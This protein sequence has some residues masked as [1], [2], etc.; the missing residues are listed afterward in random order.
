MAVPSQTTIYLQSVS[1]LITTIPF[2]KVYQIE[3][4][5]QVWI[6]NTLID[7]SL[8]TWDG[9]NV[10]FTPPKTLNGILYVYLIVPMNRINNFNTG[11]ALRLDDI[12]NQFDKIIL[13]LQSINSI[14][15][16]SPRYN[17]ALTPS[18]NDTDLT[19]LVNSSYWQKS[20]GFIITKKLLDYVLT[21]PFV[22]I[23][24]VPLLTNQNSITT[25]DI[26]GT[27]LNYT[28]YSTVVTIATPIDGLIHFY[29]INNKNQFGKTE[30]IGYIYY[31]N[32]IWNNTTKDNGIVNFNIVNNVAISLNP[33]DYIKFSANLV[34][35]F[36]GNDL[37]F[38]NNI[39][40]NIP[41]NVYLLKI[42]FNSYLDFTISF[43]TSIFGAVG[44]YII[45]LIANN[46]SVVRLI[47]QYNVIQPFN[48]VGVNISIKDIQVV[49]KD[50]EV[51]VIIQ[52]INGNE[53]QIM[54]N[55]NGSIIPS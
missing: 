2:N 41:F 36:A 4:T 28:N 42:P 15:L 55:F 5:V 53:Q 1:G 44:S 39:V 21:S 32:N 51:T 30:R 48:G 50:D 9:V 35:K 13:L 27:I 25:S 47:K 16:L 22:F 20:N 38:T 11:S 24:A 34:N 14:L 31:L 54:I 49:N 45:S 40:Y 3:D 6:D 12:N 10:T 19:L 7:S 8:Y 46:N 26:Y 29:V 33:N 37:W 52:T 17:I 23:I 18:P 43:V